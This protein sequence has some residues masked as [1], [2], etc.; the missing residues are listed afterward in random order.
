MAVSA[1]EKRV[2][3]ETFFKQ[4]SE[5]L[6]SAGKTNL[7]D[8]PA[9]SRFFLEL[10]HNEPGDPPFD[11]FHLEADGA[12][13]ATIN[14]VLFKDRFYHFNSTLAE[15]PLRRHSPGQLLT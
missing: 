10:A 1:D 5:Q 9:I 7:I 15:T 13:V 12:V 14:G 3:V 4:K 8:N 6:A 11:L 2:A